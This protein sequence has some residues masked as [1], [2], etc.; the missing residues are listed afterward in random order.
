MYNFL[1]LFSVLLLVFMGC[2]QYIKLFLSQSVCIKCVC[3][4]IY[5][6]P[7]FFVFK[8]SVAWSAC[9]SNIRSETHCVVCPVAPEVW[10]VLKTIKVAAISLSKVLFP[11]NQVPKTSPFHRRYRLGTK[12]PRQSSCGGLTFKDTFSVCSTWWREMQLQSLRETHR[13]RIY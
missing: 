7:P 4:R 11:H 3:V 1:C 9:C 13:R 5:C 6:S 2:L 8:V 10:L 12:T